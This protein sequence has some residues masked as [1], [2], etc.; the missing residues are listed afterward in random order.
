MYSYSTVSTSGHHHCFQYSRKSPLRCLLF[1]SDEVSL[2]FL[3][4]CLFLPEPNEISEYGEWKEK[5]KDK[6]DKNSDKDNNKENK[7][8]KSNIIKYTL[9]ND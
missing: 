4:F 7:E 6:E 8:A 9:I 1:H 5:K 3:F 2:F